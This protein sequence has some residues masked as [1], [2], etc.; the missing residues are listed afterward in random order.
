MEKSLKIDGT[1]VRYGNSEFTFYS[2]KWSGVNDATETVATLHAHNHFELHFITKGKCTYRT[3]DSAVTLSEGEFIIFSPGFI[4]F[5]ASPS[6]VFDTIVLQFNL[7]KKNAKK[8]IHEYFEQTLTDSAFKTFKCTDELMD[9]VKKTSK[10]ESLTGFEAVCLRKAKLTEFVYNLFKCI[11]NFNSNNQED[12]V[13][14]D[15]TDLLFIID[16]M[17]ISRSFTIKDIA[18]KTGYSTRNIARLIMATY[19]M[20]Y[21]D[22][23]RKYSLDTAKKMLESE[24]YTIEQVA[25]LSGFK[26]TVAMRNAFKKYENTIP[27][28]YKSRYERKVQTHENKNT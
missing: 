7:T 14:G 25:K 20:S 5:P 1:P 22:I 27:S 16:Q 9:A 17:V 2:I 6:P 13:S 4:H 3:P 24:E 8:G 19:K 11:N 28:E 15:K 18:E 10:C 21:S 23:K 12:R 26:N